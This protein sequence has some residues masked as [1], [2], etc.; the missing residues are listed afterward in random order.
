V[1]SL[2]AAKAEQLEKLATAKRQI[3]Q[4]DVIIRELRREVFE[5]H[6]ELKRKDFEASMSHQTIDDLRAQLDNCQSMTSAAE[7]KYKAEME[8]AKLALSKQVT[9]S[10]QE[11]SAEIS[12]AMVM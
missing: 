10:R 7:S 12:R 3:D 2:T 5:A 11:L 6:E 4:L 9:K 1:S 8:E